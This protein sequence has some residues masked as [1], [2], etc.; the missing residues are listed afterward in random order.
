MKRETRSGL[1]W[2]MVSYVRVHVCVHGYG[3][4]YVRG[5]WRFRGG[6]DDVQLYEI[7]LLFLGHDVFDVGLEEGGCIQHF[8]A[9]GAL[10]GG[11]NL[12][13][14]AGGYAALVSMDWW[15]RG[16]AV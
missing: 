2:W 6:R 14:C 3:C 12:R 10:D 8:L 1:W 13:L 9:D 7:E 15:E 16:V 5:V 11:L 4:V